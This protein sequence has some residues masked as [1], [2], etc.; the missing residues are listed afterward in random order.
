MT[1]F[2]GPSEDPPA[3]P[4]VLVADM[5]VPDPAVELLLLLGD[6]TLGPILSKLVTFCNLQQHEP[7]IGHD[8]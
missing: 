7:I 8:S 3:L 6:N 5:G 2:L 4:G 1:R